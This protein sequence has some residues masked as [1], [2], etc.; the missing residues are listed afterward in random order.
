[1]VAA[2]VPTPNAG[3]SPASMNGYVGWYRRD[4]APSGAFAKYVGAP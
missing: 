2:T 3:N 1:V 4:F